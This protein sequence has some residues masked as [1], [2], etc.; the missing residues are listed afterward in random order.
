MYPETVTVTGL[1]S[2]MTHDI[3]NA[4]FTLPSTSNLELIGKYT[5]TLRSEIKTPNDYTMKTSKVILKE[6]IVTVYV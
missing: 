1:P 4:R 3:Q 5:F 2:F 6:E